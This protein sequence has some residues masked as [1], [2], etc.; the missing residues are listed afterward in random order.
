MAKFSAGLVMY[1]LHSGRLE[2]LLVHPGGPFW[3]KKDFG[4]WS[5]PKGEVPVGEDPLSAAKRE[6]EEELGFTPHG[7]FVLLGTITQKAEKAVQVW[8]F[9]G[10]C[11]PHRVRSNTFIMEWPPRSAANSRNFLRSI[12]LTF[13]DWRKRYGGSIPHKWS[14]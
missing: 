12:A 10:N 5:I 7:E 6:F 3:A 2:V 1:R 14:F 4:A 8:A 13:L 9:E 11:D